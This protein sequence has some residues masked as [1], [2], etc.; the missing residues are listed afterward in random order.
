MPPEESK[1]SIM[2]WIEAEVQNAERSGFKLSKLLA[3]MLPVLEEPVV[4]VALGYA[5][6]YYAAKGRL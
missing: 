1:Q 4:D 6:G 3:G 5:L 2:K